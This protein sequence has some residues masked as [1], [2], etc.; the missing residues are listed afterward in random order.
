MDV[1]LSNKNINYCG[2]IDW[3]DTKHPVWIFPATSLEFCFWGNFARLTVTNYQAYWD[4]YV[5]AIVDGVQRT[6]KLNASGQTELIL[7]KE[8]RERRHKVVFFKR[9]DSCHLL[10]L[11]S[12]EL[13]NGASLLEPPAKPRRR[14][15]VY[16]DSVSAGEVSE[17]IGCVGKPDPEHNGEYSNSWYSYAW[18]TA[19]KLNACLHDIAQGGI[20][21]LDGTGW[22]AP[23]YPGMESVWDKL[24]YH[25]SFHKDEPWD[26]KQYTPHLVLVAIG[27]NDNHPE[28]YMRENPMG[29][30]ALRWIRRY[31]EFLLRLRETYPN[32]FIIA[33]T[34]I[35]DHDK[36]WDT[37][38]D[39]ACRELKDE[40]IVHFMFQRNGSGTP[41]HI[42]I[43]EAEEMSEELVA[44]IGRLS[45]K[46]WEDEDE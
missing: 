18:M 13:N 10:R 34:T 4:N 8:E 29:E 23:G 7:C 6:W 31:K 17:A 28:D 35:L 38:I 33:M 36:N 2:R 19:R 16:G 27:Q 42:R 11:D 43:S 22:V 40:R 3:S 44:Y 5:G 12:L 32:A 39:S 41:G 26:F 24:H 15:E 9:M 14:M 25:P 37:A 1:S 30:K 45:A 20:P 21:L 46:I